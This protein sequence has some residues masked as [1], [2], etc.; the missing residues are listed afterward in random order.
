MNQIELMRTK[1]NKPTSLQLLILCFAIVGFA[2]PH[3][4]LIAAE[5]DTP[6]KNDTATENN[7][8]D[9]VKKNLAEVPHVWTESIHRVT[10]KEYEATLAY[11]QEQHPKILNVSRRGVSKDGL[12]IHLLK[13]TDPS[14]TD[15]DKQVCL[16]TSLHGGPERTGTSAIL[17]LVEWLLGDTPQAAEVRKKQVV[18]IMPI[19]NPRSYF[20]TDRFYNLQGIDPYTGGKAEN[21]DFKTMTYK[22]RDDVP[23]IDAFLSVVD[24]YQPEIHADV[25]GMG[26]QEFPED[27]LG[28]RQ[29]FQGVM[30]FEVVGSAYSNSALRPWD[31]RV[32]EAII[33]AGEKAGY[34]SDRFE[35]DAQRLPGG[36]ATNALARKQWLGRP[37]FYTA[38]Y[39]YA[40]YHTM[41]M[42]FESSWEESALAKLKGLL[43]IG[44]NKWNSEPNVGYPVNRVAAYIGNFVTT[45]GQTASQ[46][47]QSRVELW[48]S[49]PAFTQA[50][51]YPQAQGRVAFA[52]TN[53]PGMTAALQ[54]GHDEVIEACQSRENINH[55]AIEAFLQDG[56]EIK[57]AVSPGAHPK[58]E[59][60]E[61]PLPT[62]MAKLGL[63]IR[64]RI[65]Y[66]NPRL[67]DIR[68]NGHLIEMSPTDGYQRWYANGFTHLQINI[69]PERSK[70]S[71]TFLITCGY[72]PDVERRT[73][74]KPPE[75]VLQRLQKK[76]E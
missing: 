49:Q 58:K 63:G 73:G 46:R 62:G 39:G 7:T 37:L 18:L 41:I 17:H 13:I 16:I 34:G 47:R 2:L 74:W 15:D 70:L 10:L 44:N 3:Q 12:K 20:I 55:S 14:V 65:P 4:L 60:S 61:E 6:T 24:E 45:W 25:H 42:T 23:E 69:P 71:D 11:W 53:S 76:S 21:W 5:N 31:W 29:M 9:V 1:M 38:H 36:P 66:R 33:K 48:N 54:S 22:R 59:T 32:S 64:L 26:L 27:Q 67:V 75:E 72:V 50:M 19:V 57:W 56:P 51:L 43:E 68:V 8:A 30:M 28:N 40:K 35:A 52:V